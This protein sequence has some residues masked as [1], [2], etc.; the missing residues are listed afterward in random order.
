MN[1]LEAAE[2][3]YTAHPFGEFDYDRDKYFETMLCT[4][5]AGRLDEADVVYDIG[6]GKGYFIG[7]LKKRITNRIIGVDISDSALEHCRRLGYEVYKMNNMQL[8]LADEVSGFTVSNGVIHHTPDP[9]QS[10]AELVR[11]TRRRKS[12]Y[13]SVYRK[14]FPYHYIYLAAAPL[15]K[16][17]ATQES[18][19][20][21][22]I[23]PIF[24]VGYFVPIFFVLERRLVNRQTA[25]TLFADQILTPQATFHT[26]EELERWAGEEGCRVVEFA[27]EKKGQMIS[28]LIER[29]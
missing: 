16:L 18:F 23:F 22:V 7:F 4:V 28:A 20:Y 13:V 10:F 6:C 9:R 12:I 8:D 2:R 3:L 11:I 1:K 5:Q 26:R 29:L 19:V 25:M 24:Y 14:H 27:V 21:R 17:Y 15:R